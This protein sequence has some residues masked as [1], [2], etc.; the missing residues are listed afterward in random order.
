MKRYFTF[1]NIRIY[2]VFFL[3]VIFI[4]VFCLIKFNKRINSESLDDPILSIIKEPTSE[5]IKTSLYNFQKITYAFNLLNDCSDGFRIEVFGKG[6]L[7][8]DCQGNFYKINLNQ[9]TDKPD[10]VPLPNLKIHLNNHQ[11]TSFA[12]KNNFIS[13]N[14]KILFPLEVKSIKKFD[15]NNYLVSYTQW[16]DNESCVY[17]EVKKITFTDNISEGELSTIFRT[18]DCIRLKADKGREFSGAQSGGQIAVLNRDNFLLSIGD[19]E[20]DGYHTKENLP[21]DIN[22]DFGKVLQINI[23]SG[24]KQIFTLGHRNPQGLLNRNGVIFETEH[25]PKGGDEINILK[26]GFNYGWPFENYGL[27]YNDDKYPQQISF[28]NHDRYEQPVFAFMPDIGISSLINIENFNE[29]INN[30]L[31]VGSLINGIYRIRLQKNKIVY[32]DFIPVGDRIRNI[33]QINGGD[34]IMLS[35]HSQKLIMLR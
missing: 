6:V 35:K 33:V 8:S 22:S 20:Y 7:L 11:L 1:K 30:D 19:F 28:A 25:G 29:K 3:I 13:D 10:I 15:K 18:D 31:L 14:S 26:K 16:D 17:F 2:G 21:Q 34:I 23:H 4:F 27:N 5:S 24:K 32:T 9:Q 12:I